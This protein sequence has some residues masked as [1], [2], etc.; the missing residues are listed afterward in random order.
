MSLKEIQKILDTCLL[1]H[2]IL[3]HPLRRADVDVRADGG[4]IDY[5]KYVIYRRVTSGGRVYGDGKKQLGITTYD[6]NLYYAKGLDDAEIIRVSEIML[7]IEKAF[8]AAGW[9]ILNGQN[10]LYDVEIGQNGLN[11][12]VAK[13]GG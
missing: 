10:D 3:S 8:T 9:Y 12:E 11:I 7:E 13:L 1:P 2:G 5:G 4:V 6:V